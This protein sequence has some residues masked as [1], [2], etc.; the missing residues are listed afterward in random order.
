[1]FEIKELIYPDKESI[2][3]SKEKCKQRLFDI[4]GNENTLKY[5]ELFNNYSSIK[6]ILKNYIHPSNKIFWQIT[7]PQYS[8]NEEKIIDIYFEED[9]NDIRIYFA[10]PTKQSSMFNISKLD[11]VALEALNMEFV[12][13]Q[14]E[15][16]KENSIDYTLSDTYRQRVL[17]YAYGDLE[18]SEENSIV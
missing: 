1:M 10:T 14:L 16:C 7:S 4:L 3:K 13:L 17:K 9:L 8:E 5:D 11:D 6:E 12:Y 15:H 18:I 2:E